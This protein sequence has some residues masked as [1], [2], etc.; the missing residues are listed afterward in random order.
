MGGRARFL[1]RL[2]SLLNPKAQQ[3]LRSPGGEYRTPKSRYCHY[4]TIDYRVD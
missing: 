4:H 2:H 3:E 1:P